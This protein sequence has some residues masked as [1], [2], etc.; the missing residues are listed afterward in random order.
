MTWAQHQGKI[1]AYL[2]LIMSHATSRGAR[3]ASEEWMDE[4][5]EETDFYTL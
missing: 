3:A 5:D 2:K 1:I 4:D